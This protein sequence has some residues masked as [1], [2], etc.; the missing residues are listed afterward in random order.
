MAMLVIPFTVRWIV[1]GWRVGHEQRGEAKCTGMASYS[2]A[3]WRAG[4]EQQDGATRGD[5]PE[6]QVICGALREAC[7]SGVWV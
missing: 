7:V 5:C 4:H 2:V 1:A 6:G 3:G